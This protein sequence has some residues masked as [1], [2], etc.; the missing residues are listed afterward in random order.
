MALGKQL[1]VECGLKSLRDVGEAATTRRYAGTP[2]AECLRSHPRAF[3]S[4]PPPLVRPVFQRANPVVRPPNQQLPAACRLSFGGCS[5]RDSFASFVSTA[6][7]LVRVSFCS[8]GRLSDPQ[9]RGVPSG[10]G[11]LTNG[12]PHSQFASDTKNPKDRFA[13]LRGVFV[14]T[15]T[16]TGRRGLSRSR[17]ARS[18]SWRS[19]RSPSA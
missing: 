3:A 19:R 16:H 14:P 10:R 7:L 11:F 9:H 12:R 8:V 5:T 18:I 6:H 1:M 4:T 17:V 15:G 13:C 2:S